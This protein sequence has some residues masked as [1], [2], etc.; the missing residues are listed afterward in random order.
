M[1]N[2]TKGIHALNNFIE[3]VPARPQQP[4]GEE[5]ITRRNKLIAEKKAGCRRRHQANTCLD[6]SIEKNCHE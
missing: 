6:L 3:F 2:N 5:A 1:H 4:L